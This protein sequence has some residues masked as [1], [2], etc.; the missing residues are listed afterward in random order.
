VAELNLTFKKLI[1]LCAIALLLGISLVYALWYEFKPNNPRQTLS[2]AE[3]V[4]E[5]FGLKLTLMLEKTS[6]SLGE[7]VNMTLAVTDIKNQ[8]VSFAIFDDWWDFL[9]YN[10]TNYGQNGLS[11]WVH[12]TL[13]HGEYTTLDPGMNVTEV[14]SWPQTC[15]ATLEGNLP[16]APVSPGTYYIVG[17]YDDYGRDFDYNLQT[18]PIEITIT[19][20]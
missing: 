9:V 2:T 13:P 7:P 5:Q 12:M 4:N 15:N 10:V 16:I 19:K 3:G 20:P 8:T 18:T 14:V 1:L 11:T 17:R 6:Y